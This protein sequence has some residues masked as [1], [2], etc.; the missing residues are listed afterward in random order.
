M[1]VFLRWGVFILLLAFV[2]LNVYI[3]T[4]PSVA[5]YTHKKAVPAISNQ[6]LVKQISSFEN[7]K[8][9]S[10]SNKATIK[11]EKN[12]FEPLHHKLCVA[13]P[14]N[15]LI[16]IQNQLITDTLLVQ[17]IYGLSGNKA[18]TMQWRLGKQTVLKITETI[19][20]KQ[21]LA[22]FL[23]LANSKSTY[24]KNNYKNLMH[25]KKGNPISPLSELKA[26]REQIT[27][28]TNDTLIRIPKQY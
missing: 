22:S 16:S 6:E 1:K 11:V 2:Y 23:G 4:K 25:F 5:Y 21:K 17:H 18:S 27:P 19:G 24:I 13:L 20:A 14:D 15:E 10:L 28:P 7:W 8:H 3:A 12:R 9:A 26:I